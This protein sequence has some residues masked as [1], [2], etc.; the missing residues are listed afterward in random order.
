[1]SYKVFRDA[2]HNMITLHSGDDRLTTDPVDWGD[3]LILDLIDTPE[4]QRLRR[5]GQLGPAY[6][7]YP[8]AEH[9]RFSHALGVLH[10]SKRI[11][12]HLI[13]L[14]PHLFDRREIAQIKA[15]ALLHDIGHGPYSHAFEQLHPKLPDHETWSWRIVAGDTGVGRTLRSFCHRHGL[16]EASFF[17][18]LGGMLG[19]EPSEGVIHIG[20]QIISSQLD[21]DRMDYLLRDAHFSGVSYGRFDLEWLLHSLAL[22]SVEGIPRL[23][24]DLSKGPAALES[25]LFAR[26]DMYRQVYDHKTVRGFEVLMLHLFMAVENGWKTTGELPP[27]TPSEMG[28]F[29]KQL[30]SDT[31][32]DLET[33]AYLHLDDT[34]VNY[35]IQHWLRILPETDPAWGDLRWKCALFIQRRP[36]Y[37]RLYWRSVSDSDTG[38][39]D[40]ISD[41]A[42]TDALAR[43][44][45][46]QG[47]RSIPLHD[48]TGNPL[49]QQAPL[50]Q[51]AHVDRL[52][53]AAYSQLHYP[54]Q[55]TDSITVIDATGSIGRAERFSERI[56]LLGSGTRHQARLFVDP[57]AERSVIQIIREQFTHPE[58]QLA[59][60]FT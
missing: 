45:N 54:G 44:V 47:E 52:E 1:M 41:P 13:T 15:A 27:G 31:P 33:E 7:V 29:L 26:D 28:R 10:L 46:Q 9:S 60:E 4:M 38:T 21:A 24:V 6:R 25:Y 20:R 8:S 57:R 11:L 48:I 35:A 32:S 40:I 37:R 12:S 30:F 39:T 36:L 53:R 18:G 23:C 14:E 58:W 56:R 5:I 22:R 42:I 49:D 50:R 59:E 16:D 17:K 34:V 55:Q 19:M 3:S 51:V 2:V 43:I